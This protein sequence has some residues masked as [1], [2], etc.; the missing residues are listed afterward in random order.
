MPHHDVLCAGFPCQPFSKSGFQNGHEDTRGT[1]F[2]DVVEVARKYEPGYILLENVGNFEQHDAGRTWQIAKATLQSLCYAVVATEHVK[3]G[4]HGL[5]SPHHLGFPQSRDRFYAVALRGPLRDDILHRWNRGE[6][7][8][9]TD[10]LQDN[11]ELHPD[12]AAE[13]QLSLQQQECI[14]PW[15]Q[16]DQGAPRGCRAAIVSS[17]ERRMWG[18]VRIRR[19]DTIF[20]EV[21][22]PEGV[23]R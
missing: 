14:P 16:A 23:G 18:G 10:I 6:K 20:C 7:T 12:A 21:A 1:L 9:V 5:I 4:G 22:R 17:V 8:T 19:R 15:E 11:N 13:L 2:H 3:S